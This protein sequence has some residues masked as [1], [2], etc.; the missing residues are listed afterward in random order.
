MQ[1]KILAIVALVLMMIQSSTQAI[2]LTTSTVV[3]NLLYEQATPVLLAIIMLV[4]AVF[5]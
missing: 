3:G 5:M 4:M 1:A 2:E